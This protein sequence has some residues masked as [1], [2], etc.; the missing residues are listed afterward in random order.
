MSALR[1]DMLCRSWSLHLLTDVEGL[2][3]YTVLDYE[4]ER[5]QCDDISYYTRG[6]SLFEV[7]AR[8]RRSVLMCIAEC[9]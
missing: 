4:Q 7:I 6:G 1:Q 9:G 3:L 8:H 2:M 5:E